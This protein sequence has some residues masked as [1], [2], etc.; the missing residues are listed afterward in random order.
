[1][2][3]ENTKDKRILVRLY[4]YLSGIFTLK[5]KSNKRH[6]ELLHEMIQRW[7]IM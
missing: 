5:G 2:A 1:M 7:K 6:N 4:R 3:H